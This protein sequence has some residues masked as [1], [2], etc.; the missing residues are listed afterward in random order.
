MRIGKT[1]TICAIVII[2]VIA[3]FVYTSS[4]NGNFTGFAITNPI[5]TCKE[6]QVPYQD[7]EEYQAPLKYTVMEAYDKGDIRGFDYKVKGIVKIKNVDSE[8]GK[9]TVKMS[10]TTL[11]K[12]TRTLSSSKY[13]MP[14][15]VI[16]FNEYY[17]VNLGEDVNFDYS[18]VPGEKTLTRTV[19]KY[20]TEEKCS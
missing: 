4:R 13:I 8:T 17:D 3:V 5:K 16:E 2:S 10:F 12:G 20:R 1:L 7:T 14:G 9:F 11:N 19:T 15:E 18:I 6:V